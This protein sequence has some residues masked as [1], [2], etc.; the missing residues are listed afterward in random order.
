MPAAKEKRAASERGPQ[1]RGEHTRRTI[2][3]ATLRLIARLGLGSV[4]FREVALE[5]GVSL[6]VTTYHFASRVDLLA[7]AFA[8]HLEQIDA[9]GQ[10]FSRA[11][12]RADPDQPPD[13][14]TRAQAV[15]SLL[16]QLVFDDRDSFIAGQELTLELSRDS[17]LAARI[18]GALSDHRSEV[19]EMVALVG[20]SEPELDGEILSATFEGLALKWLARPN[21]P[22]FEKRLGR[23][24]RQLL[25]K[26][27]PHVERA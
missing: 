11:L 21:D 5:A 20:S 22:E 9:Q 15:L 19:T 16:R 18:Q 8:L 27:P 10:A 17:Q 4:T 14:D 6:G 13:L 1:K 23:V 26:Y 2:L 7:A 25:G 3:E 12:E 24:V